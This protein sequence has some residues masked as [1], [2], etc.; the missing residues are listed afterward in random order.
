MTRQRLGGFEGRLRAAFKH[1]LRRI[2][3]RSLSGLSSDKSQPCPTGATWGDTWIAVLGHDRRSLSA[4]TALGRS[5]RGKYCSFDLED[6]ARH[7]SGEQFK[8]PWVRM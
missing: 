8:L 7:V 3:R 2:D 4:V 1:A 6:G 5:R